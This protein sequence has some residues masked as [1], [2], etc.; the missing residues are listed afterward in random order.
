MARNKQLELIRQVT[1]KRSQAASQKTL[2]A[3]QILRHNQA[4][5][6]QL[7]DY[8]KEYSETLRQQAKRGV[9]SAQLQNSQQFLARIDVAIDQQERLIQQNQNHWQAQRQQLQALQIREQTLDNVLEQRE[10]E[11][12]AYEVKQEQKTIDDSALN[13]GLKRG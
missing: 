11:Q 5:M 9:Q 4:Q 7:L 6:A 1:Q 3:E 8:R 13:K 10:R 2:S 12:I